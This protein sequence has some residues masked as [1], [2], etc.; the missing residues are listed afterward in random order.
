MRLIKDNADNQWLR[1]AVSSRGRAASALPAVSKLADRG[2]IWPVLAASLASRPAT[3]T[4]GATGLGAVAAT[5]VV[6][7]GVQHVVRRRRPPRM[8]ALLSRGAFDRPSNPSFPSTHAANAAAFA[9][10]VTA[11]HPLLGIALLPLA[12]AVSVARVGIGHHYPSDVVAGVILG[13][14]M[15]AGLGVAVRRRVQHPT[16]EDEGVANDCS[17]AS[18]RDHTVETSGNGA[19]P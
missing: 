7:G 12:A 19:L 18:P 11:F 15:G 3:R 4:A 17:S 8:G 16:P 5:T 1:R 10:A 14:G 2:F 9:T 13:S 6:T